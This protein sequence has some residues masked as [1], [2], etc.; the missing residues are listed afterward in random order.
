MPDTADMYASLAETDRLVRRE[1]LL[2]ELQ[3]IEE[4]VEAARQEIARHRS[5]CRAAEATGK[6]D[7]NQLRQA[8]LAANGIDELIGRLDSVVEDVGGR[9]QAVDSALAAM[10]EMMISLRRQI[11]GVVQRLETLS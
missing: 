5:A 1:A 10:E 2:G 4:I 3:P 7:P 9:S 11:R 8:E 6:A